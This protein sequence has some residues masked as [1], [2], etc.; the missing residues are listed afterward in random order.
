VKRIVAIVAPERLDD[1]RR[2]LSHA[3]ISGLTVGEV[4]A[5]GGEGGPPEPGR[6]GEGGGAGDGLRARLRVEVVVPDPLVPRLL[7]DLERHVRTGRAGD[8]TLLVAPV[9]EAVRIRTGERG[10]DA[11]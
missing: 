10:E 4:H 2:A 9:V 3:W 6:A 7:H 1:V 8:G 11:L 5:L